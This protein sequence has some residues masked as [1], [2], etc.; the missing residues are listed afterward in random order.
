M[1]TLCLLAWVVATARAERVGHAIRSWWGASVGGRAKTASNVL[2]IRY[3]PL[4]YAGRDGKR[5]RFASR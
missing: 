2:S 5:C 1:A 4:S 3:P